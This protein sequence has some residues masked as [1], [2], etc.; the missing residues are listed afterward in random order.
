MVRNLPDEL[1]NLPDELEL[2]VADV[3]HPIDVAHELKVFVSD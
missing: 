3:L 2:A 1:R